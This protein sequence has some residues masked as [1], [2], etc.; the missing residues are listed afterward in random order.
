MWRLTFLVALNIG[1]L[2]M[3]IDFSETVDESRLFIESSRMKQWTNLAF[4]DDLSNRL[5]SF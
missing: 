2:Y 4:S 1:S 5:F 3:N